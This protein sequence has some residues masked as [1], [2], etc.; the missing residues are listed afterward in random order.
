MPPRRREI[1]I[2]IVQA[3]LPVPTVSDQLRQC[4]LVER[5]DIDELNADAAASL[6]SDRTVSH[7]AS[8]RDAV[9][10]IR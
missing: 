3:F 5:A 2:R 6:C 10:V 1:V 4:A 7:F 8:Q 9:G